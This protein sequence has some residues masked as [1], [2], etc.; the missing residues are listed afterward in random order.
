MSRSYKKHPIS[1]DGGKSSKKNKQ[2]ANRIIRRKFKNN[3]QN[4]FSKKGKNYKKLYDSW[5]INDYI[6]YWSKKDAINDWNKE[7]NEATSRGVPLEEFG[8]HSIYK[9]LEDFLNKYWAKT[10]KRK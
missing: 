10:S 3:T 8:W 9:S 5:E 7:V 1:K 6:S 2:I 4:I